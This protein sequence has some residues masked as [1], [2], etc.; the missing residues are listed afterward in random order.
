MP[1]NSYQQLSEEDLDKETNRRIPWTNRFKEC[2]I[3]LKIQTQ[4]KYSARVATSRPWLLYLLAAVALVMAGGTVGYIAADHKHLFTHRSYQSLG[5]CGLTSKDNHD[6]NCVYDFIMGSW[7]DARCQDSELYTKYIEH[8]RKLNLTYYVDQDGTTEIPLDVALQGDHPVLYTNG[9]QHH[10]H[11]TYFWEKQWVAWKHGK[12]AWDSDT[13]SEEHTMHCIMLNGLPGVEGL[14]S[15]T[16]T[17][18]Y[19]PEEGIECMYR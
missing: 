14:L 3:V 16:A 5:S 19:A 1:T 18:I 12:R 4:T 17:K 7:I 9:I 2:W 10:L 11:C 15:R 6:N 8:V 13:L